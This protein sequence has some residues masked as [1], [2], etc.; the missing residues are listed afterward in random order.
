MDG[1]KESATVSGC[2]G[3]SDVPDHKTRATE[4]D[5]ELTSPAMRHSL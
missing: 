5:L 4:L 2:G 3:F 1:L